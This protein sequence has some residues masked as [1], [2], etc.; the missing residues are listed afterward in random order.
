MS[1]FYLQNSR[2]QQVLVRTSLLSTPRPKS[3]LQV[4]D[5]YGGAGVTTRKIA[6]SSF[7]FRSFYLI[8]FFF[9]FLSKDGQQESTTGQFNLPCQSYGLA[10]KWSLSCTPGPFQK[11]LAQLVPPVEKSKFPSGAQQ[12]SSAHRDQLGARVCYLQNRQF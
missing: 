9:F 2:F 5:F 3:T 12:Q 8:C 4:V 11:I 10:T 1:E 6:K 7:F